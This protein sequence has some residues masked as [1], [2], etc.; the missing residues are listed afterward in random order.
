MAR[1]FNTTGPC[2]PSEHDMLDAA[3]RLPD[4]TPFIERKQ[5]F[6]LHAPRQT[7]K[8]TAMRGLAETLRARGIAAFWATLE[9]SQG[10][11][12]LE[13]AEPLWLQALHQW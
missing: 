5:Y 9:R 11:E 6:V 3:V 4:L 1:F 8:T 13:R 10:I 2:D 12:D 7:G